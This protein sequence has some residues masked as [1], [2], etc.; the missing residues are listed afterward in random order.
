MQQARAIATRARLLEA[1]VAA[2]IERGIAGA[3][4][5][6]IAARAGVSQGA[7]FKHF[8]T[9]AELLAAAV[10]RAL[11]GFVETFQ[12]GVSQ[13]RPGDA[14]HRAFTVLWQIFRE[15]A[16]RA[17]FEVYV[18]ARTDRAL[19]QLLAPILQRHRGAILTEARRLFP[20]APSAAA[21]LDAA[22]DAI[23]YAMQ[24]A[25]LGV[26]APDTNAES[27]QIAFLERLARRELDRIARTAP[28]AVR[29]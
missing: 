28:A 24:G 5:P 11:A 27:Q 17:V 13:R 4:T 29:A 19:T 22:V 14:I 10:E 8:P 2:L 7:V 18:A 25:A 1:A 12:R 16:M 21:E 15:P 23:V 9:K 20:V 26:F 3:S 6:D